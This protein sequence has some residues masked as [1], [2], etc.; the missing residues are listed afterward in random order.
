[1]CTVSSV[2]MDCVREDVPVESWSWVEEVSTAAM[3]SEVDEAMS[4]VPREVEII[5]T[6]GQLK[7][8]R[9]PGED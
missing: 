1:M 6:I 7:N 5:S 4:T 2:V 8:G 3:A 9:G